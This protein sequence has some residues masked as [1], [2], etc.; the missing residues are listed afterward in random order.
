MNPRAFMWLCLAGSIGVFGA[1]G[2]WQH[3]RAVALRAERDRL[4]AR[5]LAR[6]RATPALRS[7]A[8]AD[9]LAQLRRQ[10]EEWLRA[11][12]DLAKIERALASESGELIASA[13][14]KS[15]AKENLPPLRGPMVKSADWRDAGAA[16][17]EAALESF[18]W[19]ATRGETEKLATLLAID[20]AG[21]KELAAAFAQLSDEA[22]ASYGSPENMLATL[23]AVQVPQ[24]LSAIGPVAALT[25]NNGDVALRTRTERGGGLAR[26]AVLAFRRVEGSWR[27]VVPREIAV[28]AVAAAL[29]TA[30]RA[31]P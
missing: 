31:Q 6:S 27:L 3:S 14:G 18:V 1:L 21:R 25:L 13:P 30:P 23:I 19:A 17:P 10:Q 11:R 22:R 24:D 26:D 4:I 12:E 20:A 15:P 28:G 2:M 29:K 5:Q 8:T 16:A 7:S 9:E